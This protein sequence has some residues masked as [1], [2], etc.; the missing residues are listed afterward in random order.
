MSDAILYGANVFITPGGIFGSA[1]NG[2][3]RVSLCSPEEKLQEA[4]ERIGK[5][6]FSDREREQV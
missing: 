2:F 5:V 3:I 6:N 4:M 1:G